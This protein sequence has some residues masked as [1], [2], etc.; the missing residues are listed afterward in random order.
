MT[1]RAEPAGASVEI[2]VADTGDGIRAEDRPLVFDAFFRGGS[3]AARTRGGAGLG[4]AISRA[5]V[6]AH[7]GRIWLVDC[8]RGTRVRF[9]LPAQ[10]ETVRTPA[11]PLTASRPPA[12]RITP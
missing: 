6:E 8:D 10:G 1:V 12:S 3:E 7:G 9:S 2:E 4:L 5:I 11:S